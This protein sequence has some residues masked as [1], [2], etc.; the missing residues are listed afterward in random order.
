[1][2]IASFIVLIVAMLLSGCG[3]VCNLAGGVAHPEGEPRIYGGVIRD[4]DTIDKT[5]TEG[6]QGL[7]GS[8]RGGA[9]FAAALISLAV[10]DPIISLVADT[11]T[12]PV[13]IPLQ[14]RRIAR[15]HENDAAA[16]SISDPA[17]GRPNSDASDASQESHG[18]TQEPT[19]DIR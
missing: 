6:V 14:E 19:G 3:T 17:M 13:T 16:S 15:E 4:L 1:M 5:R 10:A 8:G 2:K 12:L 11:L 7:G 9:I 18:A